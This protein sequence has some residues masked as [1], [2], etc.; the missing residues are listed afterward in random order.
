MKNLLFVNGGIGKNIIF[1]SLLKKLE[2]KYN[3]KISVVTEH[4][5]VYYNNSSIEDIISDFD[6][7]DLERN[8]KEFHKFNNL[9]SYD[10]YQSIYCCNN[11]HI[12]KTWF[13]LFDIKYENEMNDIE[14]CDYSKK[15]NE[16]YG[17]QRYFIFQLTSSQSIKNNNHILNSIKN[18]DFDKSLRLI[19]LL[20]YNFPNIQFLDFSHDNEYNFNFP[21][22]HKYYGNFL[23]I[24]TLL[25]NSLGFISVD[26]SLQHL[27]ATKQIS[28]KGIVLWNS[29]ITIPDKIGYNEN[30]NIID[31][32][33]RP[34]MINEYKILETF[35]NFILTQ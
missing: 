26:S 14:I 32:C 8:K 6:F 31:N 34:I 27:A 10:P 28:K 19:S 21:N 9:I 4:N 35:E 17:N 22:V 24:Q 2:K 25:K 1:T 15:V 23:G 33:N 29:K 11:D 3:D 13:E 5:E 18:Y 20:S 12:K 30:I 16:R 7:T